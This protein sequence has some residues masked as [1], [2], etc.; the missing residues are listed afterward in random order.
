MS[1]HRV[2]MAEI[3]QAAGVSVPTVSRVL[4][5]QG[6]VSPRKRELIEDLLREHAYQPRI[7]RKRPSARLIHVVFPEIDCAWELEHIRGMEPVARDAG[8]GLVVTA[9]ARIV[10][11]PTDGVV[12]A[13]TSG[14]RRLTDEL[15]RRGIPVVALDPAARELTSPTVGAANWSGARIATTHLLG[16]GHRRIAMIAGSMELLSSRL[17]CDGFQSLMGD[18]AWVEHGEFTYESGLTLGLKVLGGAGRPTAIFAASDNVALGVYEAARRLG[19]RIPDDVSVVGF[20]DVPGTQWVSPPLTTVRQPLRDM[21]RLAADTVL[22][23]ANGDSLAD[24]V[25]LGTRLVVRAST[26]EPNG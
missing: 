7:S 6:H 23:L 16:L 25:E 13:A 26:A 15:D 24:H 17:R 18:S 8:V 5:G 1:D 21:G 10:P 11:G 3:A 14:S 19:L 4:N 20:D 12:L 2:T 9:A 22:R